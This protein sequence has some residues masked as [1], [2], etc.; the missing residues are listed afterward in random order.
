MASE[1]HVRAVV[2]DRLDIELDVPPGITVLFGP[3]GAGKTTCLSVIA[4]LLE[5]DQGTVRLGDIVLSTLPAHRRRVGLVFQSLALFPH[6]DA[7]SNVAYGARSLDE[8]RRWLERA[9]VQH[10]S[11]K[12]PAQLSGGEAQ[13]VAIARALASEP[14]V[15]LLDEPFSALDVELRQKLGEEIAALVRELQLPTLLVTHDRQDAAA[16]GDRVVELKSGRRVG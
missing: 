6:L 8:A 12:R 5:P 2:R 13:R 4:G 3:S 9:H 16:L 14:R 15:L 11:G 7:L 10:V 1:L